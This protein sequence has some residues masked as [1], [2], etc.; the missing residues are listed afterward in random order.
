LKEEFKKSMDRNGVHMPFALHFL[1]ATF[2]ISTFVNVNFI[3]TLK[4]KRNKTGHIL[5]PLRIL[6]AVRV[7]KGILFGWLWRYIIPL[8]F[9]VDLRW[10]KL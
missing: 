3:R 9:S 1:L 7:N 5:R 10:A 6:L 4:V 2:A 8:H